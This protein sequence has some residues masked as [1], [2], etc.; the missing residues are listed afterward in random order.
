MKKEIILTTLV[1]GV[2]QK[3]I[4]WRVPKY[5]KHVSYSLLNSF[6][7]Y[8]IFFIKEKDKSFGPEPK[9]GALDQSANCQVVITGFLSYV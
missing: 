9:S 7:S 1:I 4:V 3:E 5:P 8:R 2:L 6:G